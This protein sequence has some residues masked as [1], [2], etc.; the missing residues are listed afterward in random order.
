MRE[1]LIVF[2]RYPEP[3]KA[4][5]RLIPALG[6]KAAAD[7]HQKMTEYTLTTVKQLRQVHSLT[8]EVWFAGG[9]LTRMQTWLGP[10]LLYQLQPEGNLGDRMTL[11]F[12]S[13]FDNNVDAAI[14]IG[15]DCPNLTGTILAQA[16]LELQHN[17]VVLGPAT[18]GGYYL[19]G[20]RQFVPELFEAI[21]WSTERV[22]QQTVDIVSKLNLS[23]T[24]LPTLT[25]VDR[26]EDLTVL[27]EL[28][29]ITDYLENKGFF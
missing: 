13:A 12:Q 3:G 6:A 4:K 15:T 19:I 20:L 21:A 7:L 22:F 25:D 1:R 10:D 23:V 2:T 5:T 18:D 11:A 16:F 27:K 14:I 29:I 17:D 9:D 26:P 28:N 8:V 24:C